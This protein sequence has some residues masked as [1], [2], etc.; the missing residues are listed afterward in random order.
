MRVRAILN[1]DGGTLASMDVDAFAARLT[2]S[3]ES[4]GRP[5]DA[6]IVAGDDLIAALDAAAGDPAVDVLLAGGGDGTISAAAARAWQGGK[7]LAVLPAGTM[8][9]F[10]RA[11]RLPLDL[12]P[13]VK[14]LAGGRVIECDIG[15]ANG[16][17]F[18]HQYSAGVQPRIVRERRRFE[19]QTKAGKV[20]ASLRA[21]YRIFARPPSL[22]A[23]IT[24]DGARESGRYSYV[25]L[26][27][28]LYGE[29][30]MPYAD[31]LDGGVLGVYRAGRLGLWENMELAA[32]LLRGA[33]RD[34]P[35]LVAD[36]AKRVV[37]EYQDLPKR[38]FASLDGELIPMEARTEVEIRPRALKAIAP[39]SG[40]PATAG[41]AAG[42]PGA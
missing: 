13:A 6:D 19:F 7:T 33:W 30:H 12:E 31:R 27:N 17:P 34:N 18:V 3:F 5:L 4:A 36:E 39:A 2:K 42:G 21:A 10:A 1:R 15:V 25:V 28:N 11:L 29:G 20:L 23:E 37:I 8:N 24:Y 41:P 32:D 16:A 35:H 14:A 9:L 26:S 38:A 22:K 40:P